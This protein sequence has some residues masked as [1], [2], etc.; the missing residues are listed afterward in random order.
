MKATDFKT[1]LR[2]WRSMEDATVQQ[3][4]KAIGFS[5]QYLHDV[6]HGRRLPSVRFVNRFLE[7]SGGGPIERHAWHHAAARAHGWEI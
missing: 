4:G 3:M 5:A 6:E 7:Y 1:L 2:D